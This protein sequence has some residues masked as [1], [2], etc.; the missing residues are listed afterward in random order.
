M[1]FGIGFKDKNVVL[2]DFK[3][4]CTRLSFSRNDD[5]YPR[6]T[7]YRVQTLILTPPNDYRLFPIHGTM[8]IENFPAVQK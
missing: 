1:E 7:T 2:I 3:N 6:N 5:F 8:R 4:S